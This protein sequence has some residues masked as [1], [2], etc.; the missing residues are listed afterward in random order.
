[1]VFGRAP[2]SVNASSFPERSR[3]DS[4][5]VEQQMSRLRRLAAYTR[6][7][8]WYVSKPY[9]IPL[10]SDLDHRL[11]L[12]DLTGVR[13]LWPNRYSW[14][15]GSQCLELVK[16]ALACIVPVEVQNVSERDREWHE[17]GG[18]PVPGDKTSFLGTPRNPKMPNDIR[19]EILEVQR[20]SRSIRCAYDYSDY[21][22]ASTEIAGQVDLYF[23]CVAPS[24]ALPDNVIRVG[25][26]PIWP[27]LLAKARCMVLRGPVA[28]NID[29]Y[30]R[31]GTWTDSQDIRERLLTRMQKSSL[32][33]Q[34]GFGTVVFPAYL[35]ELMRARIALDAPGQ[36]P[37]TH[38]LPEAMALS[39]VVV[40]APPA[41][42]F[43][44]ALEDGVHYVATKEDGSDVV[45][46]CREVLKDQ[47]RMTRIAGNGMKFFDRNFSPQ[48]IARRILRHAVQL[49]N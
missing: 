26:F 28:K 32:R 27:R 20:G 45:E 37:I 17:R 47:E 44:E 25:Y 13:I 43:P 46:V 24:T 31:F 9:E 49:T 29:V 18:F 42:V 30:A 1:M 5:Q 14:P 3:G 22:I 4:E 2:V 41:C 16:D 15:N 11:P 38:R 23:K 19:G 21:P 34:G 12:P 48:S 6:Y 36:A 10:C 35:G 7:L 40:S 33:F 8:N 39:A